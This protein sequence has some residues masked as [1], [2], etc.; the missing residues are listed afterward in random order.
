[1]QKKKKSIILNGWFCRHWRQQLTLIFGAVLLLHGIELE[2]H[3]L[4][5]VTFVTQNFSRSPLWKNMK[6]AFVFYLVCCVFFS[7]RRSY[8]MNRGMNRIQIQKKN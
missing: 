3:I 6:Q 4:N 1:M 5:N 8:G 7:L 2:T